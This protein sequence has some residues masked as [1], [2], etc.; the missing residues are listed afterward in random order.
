M[1]AKRIGKEVKCYAPLIKKKREVN[2]LAAHFKKTLFRDIVDH[3]ANYQNL[4]LVSSHPD[5]VIYDTMEGLITSK[6]SIETV[7][8]SFM[9]DTCLKECLSQLGDDSQAFMQELKELFK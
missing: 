2:A 1:K 5:Y 7:T 8:S 6:N 4:P 3:K 9:E